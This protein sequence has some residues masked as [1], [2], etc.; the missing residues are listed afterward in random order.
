MAGGDLS[1]WLPVLSRLHQLSSL[2]MISLECNGH[3]L[4]AV[5]LPPQHCS[6]L[7]EINL[8][9]GLSVFFPSLVSPNINTLS[10]LSVESD[11]DSLD[12]TSFSHLCS[13]LCQ[14][15]TLKILSLNCTEMGKSGA[16]ELAA[17]EQNRS[18]KRVKVKDS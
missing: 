10:S 11:G 16:K 3:E 7:V 13:G 2:K 18:L 12:S 4:K 8:E 1:H 6:S 14:S 5:S 17:L 9:G 15:T